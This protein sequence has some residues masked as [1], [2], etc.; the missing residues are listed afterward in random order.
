MLN[1]LRK[2][3]CLYFLLLFLVLPLEDHIFAQEE[4]TQEETKID[5]TTQTDEI[6]P[7]DNDSEEKPKKKKKTKKS[8]KK[9][10]K[11]AKKRKLD[12][13]YE[14]IG[15]FDIVSSSSSFN[16]S[17]EDPEEFSNTTM[18]LEGM[19]GVLIGDNIEPVIEMK[20]QSQTR[21]VGAFS[22]NL[23]KMDWGVGTLFNV[24]TGERPKKYSPSINSPHFS[25]STWI[26]YVGFMLS[27]TSEAGGNSSTANSNTT[28]LSENMMRTNIMFGTRYM[29]YDH[30]GF[31]FWVS[32]NYE[33][34]SSEVTQ[35]EKTG[36]S[37]SKINFT[38]KMLSVTVLF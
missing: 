16:K 19:L 35:T 10:R 11:R 18:D 21:G 34:D 26:P 17:N 12:Y 30:I 36:G 3:Q 13:K 1:L 27:S 37:A 22:E 38:I 32:F 25:N 28:D 2:I 14:F 31:N 7:K 4:K 9:K 20:Y 29:V 6:D 15:T 33:D 8:K 5:E 24:P 23:N